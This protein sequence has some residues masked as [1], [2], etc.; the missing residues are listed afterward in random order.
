MNYVLY[1]FKSEYEV[2]FQT[3]KNQT[4]INSQSSELVTNLF[5]MQS[6]SPAWRA[7][8]LGYNAHIQ[9]D[10]HVYTSSGVVCT[11]HM[12]HETYMWR[13]C[14]NGVALVCDGGLTWTKTLRGKLWIYNKT[15][16]PNFPCPPLP[17][18]SFPS[19]SSPSLPLLFI[20]HPFPLRPF[21]FFLLQLLFSLPLTFPCFSF[22]AFP[23]CFN[24]V[25]LPRPSYPFLPSLFFP[26]SWN[27]LHITFPLKPS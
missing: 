25:P 9:T 7:P 21:P 3:E 10:A 8:P 19:P 15:N 4:Q 1:E 18:L 6:L 16:T 26:S 23:L 24:S 14:D 2:L 12:A 22:P 17:S 13:S 5:I 27:P 11:S 20:F